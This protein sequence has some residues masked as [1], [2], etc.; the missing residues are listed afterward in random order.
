M[1]GVKSHKIVSWPQT[2]LDDDHFKEEI[3]LE[4]EVEFSH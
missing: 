3:L 1:Q 4:L 2:W